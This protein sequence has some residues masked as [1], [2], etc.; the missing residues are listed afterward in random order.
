M[1]WLKWLALCAILAIP[2][3]FLSHSKFRSRQQ[4]MLEHSCQPVQ[5]VFPSHFILQF[6]FALAIL[7]SIRSHNY[8]ESVDQL[9]SKLGAKTFACSILFSTY[10]LTCEVTIAEANAF[11]CNDLSSQKIFGQSS[12][13]SSM[14]LVSVLGKQVQL[15]QYVLPTNDRTFL[16]Q[17]GSY[18]TSLRLW[19]VCV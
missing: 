13:L 10:Y 6:P 1:D 9:H 7:N 15:T 3:I 17:T 14:T 18:G 12:I 2:L 16:S 5:Q 8:L 4:F 11:M 19:S